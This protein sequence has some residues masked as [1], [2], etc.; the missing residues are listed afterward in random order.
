[1]DEQ[2][3][4]ILL[5]TASQSFSYCQRPVLSGDQRGE[6]TLLVSEGDLSFRLGGL[7]S[8]ELAVVPPRAEE[9][10]KIDQRNAVVT[11]VLGVVKPVEVAT[12]EFQVIRII[13]SPHRPVYMVV[14]LT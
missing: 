8:C 11:L 9:A 2:S 6:C 14:I 13:I 3:H 5:E 10:V 7:C 12:A 4:L 1:M